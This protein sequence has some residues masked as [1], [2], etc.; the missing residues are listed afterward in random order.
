MDSDLD[1]WLTTDDVAALAQIA[2]ATVRR[3]VWRGVLP[4]PVRKGGILL[5]WKGDIET[6]LAERRPPGRPK[7][8]AEHPGSA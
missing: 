2:T 5:W 7:R 8:L 3:Y 1:D 4:E 6:W